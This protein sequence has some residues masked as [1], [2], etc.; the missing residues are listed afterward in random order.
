[1]MNPHVMMDDYARATERFLD[2]VAATADDLLDT[3]GEGGWSA[4]QIVHHVADSEAQSYARLRRLLAEPAGS[5]IEG[6]DEAAWADAPVLG[7]RDLPIGPSIAVIGSVRAASLAVLS[8]IGPD[9]LDRA[10]THT[11]SGSYTV[12]DWILTYVAH[13]V[14]HAEQLERAVRG[15]A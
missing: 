4:R 3:H 12:R 11:E 6:Y 9:D 15:L 10:G 1:M 2:A 8:R 5:T 14:E 7:Y 13:P